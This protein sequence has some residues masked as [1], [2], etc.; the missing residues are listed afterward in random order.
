MTRADIG[1]CRGC[2]HFAHTANGTAFCEYILNTCKS[3]AKICPAGVGCTER[4]AR[5][6]P[7]RKRQQN[8][9]I[10]TKPRK[11]KKIDNER[12]MELY[13]AGASDYRIAQEFNVMHGSV[14]SW[15]KTRNL[16]ANHARGWQHP[17]TSTEAAT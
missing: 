6:K 9:V 4:T 2:E 13:L 10:S 12:A 15:R 16:P 5:K 11:L 1:Y 8:I 14:T 7:K 3:R 17:N